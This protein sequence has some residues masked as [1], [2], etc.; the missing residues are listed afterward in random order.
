MGRERKHPLSLKDLTRKERIAVL[1]A[2][3]FPSNTEMQYMEKIAWIIP[4]PTCESPSKRHSLGVRYL[5]APRIKEPK[6]RS[7]T[8]ILI[9]VIYSKHYCDDYYVV[10]PDE[11]KARFSFPMTDLALPWKNHTIEVE[12][13]AVDLTALLHLPVDKAS[14]AIKKQH[15]IRIAPTTLHDCMMNAGYLRQDGKWV[16][17]G[18]IF[19]C[20]VKNTRQSLLDMTLE[21]RAESLVGMNLSK[22]ISKAKGYMGLAL[23]IQYLKD[24]LIRIRSINL[25][26]K[27]ALCPRCEKKSPRHSI[28]TR[29]L[30]EIGLRKIT[31]LEVFYSVHS[32]TY[33]RDH[34]PPKKR[35][36][37][38]PMDHLVAPKGR[39]TNRVRRT[40]VD[41][42]V[43]AGLTLEAAEDK[44]WRKYH[45]YTPLSTIQDWIIADGYILRK[46]VYIKR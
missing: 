25:S 43:K 12:Q 27:E 13:V 32:C 7:Y 14:L 19:G 46:G 9:E 29:K 35:Y 33:F 2:K 28:R 22:K 16:Y 10:H 31:V 26:R 38:L 45:V 6:P 11:G 8:P 4:C 21:Q 44:M 37:P 39:F 42:V 36:F 18:G 20:V 30:K 23:T 1:E 40:A 3:G 41:M 17:H 5:K 15:H 34:D 24:N